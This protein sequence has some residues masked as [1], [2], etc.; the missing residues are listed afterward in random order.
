MTK[1]NMGL[2]AAGLCL[3]ISAGASTIDSCE[4]GNP[5]ADPYR[6]EPRA[7]I[8]RLIQIPAATRAR[9]AE[10]AER[11][12]PDYDDVVMIDR[13]SIR[14]TRAEYAPRLS[15]MAFGSGSK[16]CREVTRSTWDP[17]R[18]ESAMVF[19]EDGWCIARP[20]VCNNWSIIERQRLPAPAWAV[21]AL[22]VVPEIP[23]ES[24]RS[25]PAGPPPL[26]IAAAPP[27]SVAPSFGGGS[28]GSVFQGFPIGPIYS[29]G[30][31]ISPTAPISPVPELSSWLMYVA[32]ILVVLAIDRHRRS[33]KVRHQQ[34]RKLT[35]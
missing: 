24:E 6:G 16:V 35:L 9:L 12:R 11:Q 33:G 10:R 34:P 31:I 26:L 22:Y 17:S 1:R 15:Y 23:A 19:C 32:G 8:D 20:S 7:A 30:P 28:G 27:E 29:G 13:D 2:L 5:G 25:E 21:P 4:W 3:A 14:S 18:V